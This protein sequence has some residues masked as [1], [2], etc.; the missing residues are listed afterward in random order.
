MDNFN[1][2]VVIVA[3][4]LSCFNLWDKVD[5][6]VKA[7]KAPMKSLEDRIANLEHMTNTDFLKKF[8]AYDAHFDKDLKRIE[9]IEE[10]NRVTQRAILALLDHAIDG[11]DI[12]SLKKSSIELKDYLIS[13]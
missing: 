2:L 13:R 7:G 8:E 5:A 9:K 11:N 6:R 3:F 10:G 1:L 4:L 12:E